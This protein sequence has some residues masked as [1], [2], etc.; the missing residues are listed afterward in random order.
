MRNIELK[1]RLADLSAARR[2]AEAIVT[3][4]L[5]PQQQ[6]D[7]YFHCNCGRLK[8][9]RIEGRSAQLIWYARADQP[10]PKTSDYLLVPVSNPEM[11]QA[12]LTAAL[13]VRVVVEKRREILFYHNVRIH[14]DDVVGLGH[15]LEFEAVL[16][17]ETD[18]AEGR[19]QL[20]RLMAQFAV[21]PT[22]LL[23]GSY[24]DMLG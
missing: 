18:D 21:D 22:D 12:A 16:G 1:A 7:T 15:F 9:R 24:S 20:E 11:L 19:A 2:I 5:A 10:S 17:P 14:F 8:L 3:E 6:V 23:E 4:R 13:G